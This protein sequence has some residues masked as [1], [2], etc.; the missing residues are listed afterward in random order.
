[1][2]KKITMAKGYKKYVRQEK[3][4]IRKEISSREEQAQKIDELYARV[5]SSK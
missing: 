2:H 1:M 5:G 4:K 3:A